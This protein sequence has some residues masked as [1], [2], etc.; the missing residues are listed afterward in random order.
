MERIPVEKIPE[1]DKECDKWMYDM[2]EKKVIVHIFYITCLLFENN[3]KHLQLKITYKGNKGK[4][5][6]LT[7]KIILIKIT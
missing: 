4:K 6:S 7:L 5:L 3:F 2:Y 1:N